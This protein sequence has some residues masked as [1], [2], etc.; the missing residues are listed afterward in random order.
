MAT[1]S[2]NPPFMKAVR[3]EKWL[4][5]AEACLSPYMEKKVAVGKDSLNRAKGEDL[6]DFMQMDVFPFWTDEES[7][8][9]IQIFY[10]V[11]ANAIFMMLN[12]YNDFT[13]LRQ[14]FCSNSEKNFFEKLAE[15]EELQVRLLHFISIFSHIIV[16]VES[17]TRKNIREDISEILEDTSNEATEWIREGRLACPPR[18]LYFFSGDSFGYLPDSEAFVNIM[19]PVAVNVNPL[20]NIL[21]ISL[22]KEIND[23]GDEK[24]E[25]MIPRL[26]LWIKYARAVL[27]IIKPD[28]EIL[29]RK[30]LNQYVNR[31][32]QFMRMLN[33][34]HIK[35]AIARYTG[36]SAGFNK[37]KVIPDRTRSQVVFTKAEH[38]AKIAVAIAYLDAVL[39]GNRDEA[40]AQVRAVC[41]DLWQ[42]GMRGCE[43]ISMTG[44]RC[45][46]KVH[47]AVGDASVDPS[48]WEMHS[49]DITYLSTCSCGRR[50]AVRRDPFTLKEANYDFYFENSIFSCCTNLE[51]HVFAVLEDDDT[52]AEKGLWSANENWEE[53][54]GGGSNPLY[55]VS[56]AMSRE[57]RNSDEDVPAAT[58][59]DEGTGS[60]TGDDTISNVEPDTL[61][62][63]SQSSQDEDVRYLS[64][65]KNPHTKLDEAAIAFADRLKKLRAKQIPF[66]EGVPHSLSP[67]L[68]PLFPSWT[69]TCIGP[70]NYYTHSYG[71]RDQPNLKLGGEY[72]YP[73]TVQLEV[74]P[75]MWDR[76][77][78]YVQA[79]EGFSSRAPSRKTRRL[80]SEIE[81]V[82]LFVGM[83]YECPRGHRFFVAENGEPLRVPKNSNARIAMSRESDDEFLH[84]DFPLRRQ[85]TC[86]KL[87]V[88]AAQLMRVH[89]VTPKAPITV[90]IQPT[91]EG[92]PFKDVK[93]GALASQKCKSKRATSRLSDHLARWLTDNKMLY[94]FN[95]DTHK[96][97]TPQLLYKLT[98]EYNIP[99][100]QG[101]FGTGE[102][103]LQLSWARYYILQ[104]PFIYSGP[105]GVWIPPAGVERVGT[106]KKDA[107]QVKY[108]PMLSKK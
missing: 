23:E 19:Q 4:E 39:V 37:A 108:I 84:C 27:D 67:A 43:Q 8:M 24:L 74:D 107:I 33:A 42:G 1:S 92:F 9:S 14:I 5:E 21:Q 58:D 47:P 2:L 10:C 54:E 86:R 12:G 97:S 87:P 17:N 102:A 90:T 30:L 96:F 104:L 44:N 101:S 81:K 85:C 52:N 76:D 103:P 105:S 94:L 71:L 16:F 51:K 77:M 53:G 11:D 29:T 57:R 60:D 98:L 82:K 72:L 28:S 88:Q 34:R 66:L 59:Y 56:S 63:S 61:E 45:Q 79:V 46:L 78:Q 31:Q 89:V 25:S 50:Q 73:V 38:D 68:P 3:L 32:L 55:S 106:F 36:T 93:F 62:S 15:S 20:A 18:D 91:V 69:L 22:G 26:D 80:P 70:N 6:N 48:A 35:E 13:H 7:T 99:G 49:N 83:E 100:Q 41:D 65:V 64:F 95:I 40:I 75:V